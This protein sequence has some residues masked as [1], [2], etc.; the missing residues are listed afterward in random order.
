M[1]DCN[2][3]ININLKEEEQVNKTKPHICKHYGK[4]LYHRTSKKVHS[5]Y[6]YPCVECETDG[7]INYREEC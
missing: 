5:S 7:Y 1:P 3:C 2:I 4:R 6:L